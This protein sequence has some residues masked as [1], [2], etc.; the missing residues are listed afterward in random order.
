MVTDYSRNRKLYTTGK[1]IQSHS[2]EPSAEEEVGGAPGDVNLG[3]TGAQ[4]REVLPG[5]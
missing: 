3:T 2:L 4:S 1:A 5:P